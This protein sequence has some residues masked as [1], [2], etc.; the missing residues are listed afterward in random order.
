M[1]DDEPMPTLRAAPLLAGCALLVIYIRI[2]AVIGFQASYGPPMPG[3]PEKLPSAFLYTAG[4]EYRFWLAHLAFAIPAAL[5]I[6]WGLAPRLAPALRRMVTRID[7]AT[8]RT[9]MYAGIALF[10]FVAASSV[11][12]RA[13]VLLGM[14]ITDDENAV[15]FGAKIL[16]S[17]HLRVPVLQP[18]GA[19]PDLFT[20]IRD[21]QVSAMDFPGVLAFAALAIKTHLGGLLYALASAT[22]AVAIAG[23]AGRW[24][25]PRARV[26]AAVI[27][28]VSP[29]IASLSLTM[30]GHVPSRMLI[31]LCLALAA[32]LDTGAGTPRRDA[33]LLGAFAGLA[34]LCRP[35]ET[36]CL[37]APIGAW[38]TWR[39]LRPSTAAPAL[40]RATPLWMF[41]AVVPSILAFAWYNAQ[42][43]GVWWLQARFAA[44][45]VG[46]TPSNVQSVWD[47][48]G[49]NL[50]WN[51]LLLVVFFLGAP[52]LLAVFG[53][54][55]RRRPITIVL[56][57]SVVAGLLLCLLHDN[58]G[59]H[60]VGPIHLAEV[61]VP[62]MLLAVAGIV[63]GFAW[64]AT[65][66]LPSAPAAVVLASYLLIACGAFNLTN[67]GSLRWQAKTHAQPFETLEEMGVHNAVVMTRSY[68]MLVATVRTYA[69]WGTWVFDYPQPSPE[70]DDDII[71]AKPT[72][73]AEALHARFPGRSIYKMT[74]SLDAPTLRLELLHAPK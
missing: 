38:L 50:G 55:E 66:R 22:S 69:P 61:V 3:T 30:H 27:W 36:A 9:W 29:M 2:G 26:L 4:S 24:F 60:S 16:A 40:P 17:G 64:L 31:A 52:A 32:R 58:A 53:A 43:T 68:L 59:I 73:S 23:A 15:T 33:V 44:G 56:G 35:F 18:A 6:G 45:L 13:I 5:L 47:R 67:F 57:V 48:L 7:H 37:L 10:V 20:F 1:S 25:G 49:F 46:G 63:R 14:P 34:F 65:A 42:I 12:G 70:L 8:P 41:G 72:A 71:F 11:I 74:Y 62:L 21:G 19:Y 54:F 51:S 28:I 39:A